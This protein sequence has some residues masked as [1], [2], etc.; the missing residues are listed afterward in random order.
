MSILG[1]MALTLAVSAGSDTMLL[2]FYGDTC[3]PCRQ[4][5]PSFSNSPRRDTPCAK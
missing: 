3:P 5:G 1:A 4:M 2:D